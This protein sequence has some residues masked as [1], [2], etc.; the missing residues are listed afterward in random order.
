MHGRLTGYHTSIPTLRDDSGN[1]LPG[2][3]LNHLRSGTIQKIFGQKIFGQGSLSA[4]IPHVTNFS[5]LL[6]ARL[7]FESV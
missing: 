1:R 7:V 4:L 3:N 6:Y 2:G 5:P